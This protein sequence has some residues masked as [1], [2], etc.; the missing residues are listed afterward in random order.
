[1]LLI[2][3]MIITSSLSG[4]KLEVIAVDTPQRALSPGSTYT[5]IFKV[6]NNIGADIVC[7]PRLKIPKNWV[8]LTQE[9]EFDLKSEQGEIRLVS[10]YIPPYIAPGED[11]LEYCIAGYNRADKIVRVPVSVGQVRKLNIKLFES[12]NYI[13]AGNKIKATFNIKN[14]GNDTEEVLLFPEHCQLEG[15]P[16]IILSP[17]SVEI[18]K[19]F[20]DTDKNQGRINTR[21]LKLEAAVAD[22]DN[23]LAATSAYAQVDVFPV[24]E[25]QE[26]AFLRFPVQ[27]S[28]GFVGRKAGDEAQLVFQGELSGRGF[29]DEG[30]KRELEFR[31]FGP[32]HFNMSVLGRYD[33]Y[34]ARYKSPHL[35]LSAGDNAYRAT[36]LTEYSR[37]GRGAEISY[38]TGSI[39][40]GGF[41]Q[42]PRFYNNIRTEHN[43]FVR[44][45]INKKTNVQANYF[46]KVSSETG[47]SANL[48]SITTRYGFFAHTLLEAEFSHGSYL[49]KTGNGIMLKGKSR[50]EKLNLSF[51]YLR[52]GK[53][54]PGYYSNTG[55]YSANVNYSLSARLNFN[56]N[57]HKD[58]V[59]LRQD[60]LY[61]IA[62]V[63]NSFMG[64]V[65]WRY[66]SKGTLFLYGGTSEREDQLSASLFHYK[67]SFIKGGISQK[68]GNFNLSPDFTLG[69]TDNFLTGNTGHSYNLDFDVD[70]VRKWGLS[71][72]FFS[73]QNTS[74][75]SDN[76]SSVLYYGARMNLRRK[77]NT[78]VGFHI[79]NNYS[80]EESY[81]NRN[82]FTV[83]VKQKVARGQYIDL[84]C[85]YF[86]LQKQTTKSDLSI[87]LQYI[88][89]LNVPVKRITGYGEL[90]GTVTDIKGNAVKGIKL[91]CSG[92]SEITDENGCYKFKNLL[93]GSHYLLVDQTTVGISA[94]P[95]VPQPIEVE[96]EPGQNSFSFGMTL[97]S[98]ICGHIFFKDAD[99]PLEKL[100]D[101]N[102]IERGHVIVE[103][104]E[105]ETIKRKLVS[106]DEDFVFDNLMPGLWKVSVY[107]NGLG[108][109]Y[110]VEKG[111]FNVTLKPGKEET[112]NASVVKKAKAIRFMQDKVI[113]SDE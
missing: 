94:I 33:E 87:S 11:T 1:M 86:L 49:G 97:S 93:P 7:F 32:N 40:M 12:P 51:L 109:N 101:N 105:G 83:K 88:F 112:V 22:G 36:L 18:V 15:N 52:A 28:G 60:T 62:P 4:Q 70:Y 110:S 90:L 73:W 108:E 43:T 9:K 37:Y 89:K 34:Y 41:L 53:N 42:Q 72:L 19:V 27:V 5:F 8:E 107:R 29:I 95:D 13:L 58:A 31:L 85:N 55:Q 111:I 77:D 104:S 16:N 14:E 57:Y 47:K 84:A 67:E 48:Y 24:E 106:L 54:Y 56:L 38:N 61:G 3:T 25:T 65:N 26:D 39:V 79:Q 64:G 102:R 99:A 91:Y 96:I 63:S 20:F 21:F 66:S 78:T 44:Y 74:R 30:R 50:M 10:I 80:L 6:I 100:L 45:K 17:G 68:M 82:L 35:L 103:V 2:L 46:R 81:R 59:N 71:G 92:H 113:I 69:N 75:Y 76:K 23:R 98:K